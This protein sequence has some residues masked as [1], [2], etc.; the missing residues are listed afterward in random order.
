MNYSSCVDLVV[1]GGG[2]RGGLLTCHLWTPRHPSGSEQK[3][4]EGK[5]IVNIQ[6]LSTTLLVLTITSPDVQ[7]DINLRENVKT[8]M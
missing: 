7:A 4:N 8:K 5:Q 1:V 3:L 6:Y 2:T